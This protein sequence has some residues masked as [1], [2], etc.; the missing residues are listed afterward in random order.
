MMWP[1]IQHD[2]DGFMLAIAHAIGRNA[3]IEEEVGAFLGELLLARYPQL[4]TARYGFATEGMDGIGVV[5]EIARK[6]NCRIPGKN[7]SK[8]GDEGLDLEK[9]AML[10]LTD[11]RDG[12]LGRISL[13]TPAT[14]AAMLE[15]AKSPPPPAAKD[16][17]E[18]DETEN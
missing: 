11:Y 3:V 14:R 8:D 18:E 5:E 16:T 7:R 2:S 9:A 6:R 10:F 1:K 12:I 17:A 15:A 13:E 4:L